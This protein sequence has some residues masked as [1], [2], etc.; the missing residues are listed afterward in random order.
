[1]LLL[2]PF[3][4]YDE[5]YDS[6]SEKLLHGEYMLIIHDYEKTNGGDL[7]IVNLRAKSLG[8]LASKKLGACSKFLLLLFF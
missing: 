1:L 3:I 4:F 6:E 8:A 2:T 7:K 5:T